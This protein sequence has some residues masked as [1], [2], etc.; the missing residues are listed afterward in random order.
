MVS[1]LAPT[2][3]QRARSALD[4]LL[5][6]MASSEDACTAERSAVDTEAPRV[7][8]GGI[9]AARAMIDAG[10]DVGFTQWIHATAVTYQDP[11][12]GSGDVFTDIDGREER[13][14]SSWRSLSVRQGGRELARASVAFE[15]PPI[16]RHHPH[17]YGIGDAPDPHT[18]VAHARVAGASKLP[19]DIRPIDWVPLSARERGLDAPVRSWFRFTNE[20]PDDL[21]LHSAAA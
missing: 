18:M 10:Q 14:S 8:C 2:K 17:L 1:T 12:L 4:S 6:D 7:F 15:D 13:E 11:A 19:V 16:G 5:T 9:L 3:A 20:L 21:L